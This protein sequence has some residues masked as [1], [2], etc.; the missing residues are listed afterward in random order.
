M[1]DNDWFRSP[2]EVLN[3]TERLVYKP[4]RGIH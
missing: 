1:I 3:D 2:A 4:S